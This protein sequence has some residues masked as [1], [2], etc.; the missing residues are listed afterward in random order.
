MVKAGEI[1]NF[2]E[3]E[4]PI[5]LKYD[6]DSTDGLI[7]GNIEKEVKK[8]ILSLELRKGLLNRNAELII[9]HHPPI[10]G[11]E[12]EI[13]NP[14][15]KRECSKIIY[16]IHSR[17]DRKGLM[18]LG[19]AKK[20]FNEN[21]KIEK[22]LSDGTVIILLPER[23]SVDELIKIIKSKLKISSI[24]TLISIDYAK[25]I[26]IHGG[27]GFNRHHIKD[28]LEEGVDT[29]LAG[30]MNHHS[31][32]SA[33]FFDKNFID[34]EHVTE[35]EGLRL[36]SVILKKEFPSLNFEFIEQKTYWKIK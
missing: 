6:W 3:K 18:G 10:F 19:I 21:F 23:I 28:A 32:E 2:I 22:I 27:E 33:C 34:I 8:V 13:T 9:L 20:I 25:K 30:D 1:I 26:A 17:I 15:Y 36:L 35:Q 29:Y 4:F 12:K 7:C 14:Y 31:A 24:K 11:A 5:S 16:S